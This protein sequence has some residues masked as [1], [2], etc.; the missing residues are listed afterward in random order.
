M[1]PPTIIHTRHQT[2]PPLSATT[3]DASAIMHA[4]VPTL[5]DLP[6]TL[7][8]PTHDHPTMKTPHLAI[9]NVLTL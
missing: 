6:R 3:V 9:N 2:P 1:D 8:P 5:H 7:A 4:T